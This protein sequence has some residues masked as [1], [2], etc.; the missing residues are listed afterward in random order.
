MENKTSESLGLTLLLILFIAL[1]LTHVINWPW[2]WVLSPIW[3]PI[4]LVVIIIAFAYLKS[5]L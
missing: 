2:W 1:K 4:A 3:I 5:K